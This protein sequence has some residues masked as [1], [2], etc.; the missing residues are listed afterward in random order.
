MQNVIIT[1]ITEAFTLVK[2]KGGRNSDSFIISYF[3]PTDNPA[4]ICV[5]FPT[6]ILYLY[7]P[8][9]GEMFGENFRNFSLD[10]LRRKN[11]K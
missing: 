6:E 1:V 4:E 11:I 8:L 2:G 7:N 5:P 9:R 10:S 3:L